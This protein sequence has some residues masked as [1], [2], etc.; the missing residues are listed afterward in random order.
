MTIEYFF[1]AMYFGHE[2]SRKKKYSARNVETIWII[3]YSFRIEE[4]EK[5]RYK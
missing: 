1:W 5:N 2:I 3:N 4:E